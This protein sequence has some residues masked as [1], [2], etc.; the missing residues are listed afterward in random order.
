MD[1]VCIQ[2]GLVTPISHSLSQVPLD[3]PKLLLLVLG[4]SI[5]SYARARRLPVDGPNRKKL[6][7]PFEPDPSIHTEPPPSGL[8][9]FTF[10][11]LVS[12]RSVPQ[13]KN[14]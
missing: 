4:L 13:D 10:V 12:P 9:L 11:H 8:R 3:H 14:S 1:S 7:T 6:L 2:R 5:L